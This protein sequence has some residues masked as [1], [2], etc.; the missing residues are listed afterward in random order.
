MT[1]VSRSTFRV[2]YSEVDQMGVAYH[3]H[4]LVW[5]EI[6]RTD[7]IR[8]HGTSYA[9]LE[10]SGLLLAVIEANVRYAAPARYDD[11]ITIETRLER[12]QSR[13]LTFGYEIY[14]TDPGPR[15]RLATAW[16]KLVGMTRE[17]VARPLP[18]ELIE[19]FRNAIHTAERA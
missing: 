14:R 3:V 18:P 2:R 5:C 9:E 10:R 7:F 19:T 15:Q 8:N 16:T 13:S 4:Y 17:G 12:V 6:G 1:V 11:V